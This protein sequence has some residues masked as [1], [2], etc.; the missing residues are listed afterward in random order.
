MPVLPKRDESYA[1]RQVSEALSSN[2]S[3][4]GLGL[5]LDHSLL[6]AGVPLKRR[7][8]SP[9]AGV[10]PGRR[11]DPLR[12]VTDILGARTRSATWTSR[13]PVPG[14]RDALQLDTKLDGIPS[15]VLAGALNQAK[16]ARFTILEVMPRPSPC[17]TR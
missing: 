8:V 7:L 5:R 15:D 14:L 10:R 13:S 3:L 4:D 2:G 6:N 1:I 9:W 11:R 12:R 17:R 16:D